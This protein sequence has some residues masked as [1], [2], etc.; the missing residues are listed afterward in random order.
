MTLKADSSQTGRAR[1]APVGLR[2][3]GGAPVVAVQDVRLPPRLQQELQRSLRSRPLHNR[4]EPSVD[5]RDVGDCKRL[6]SAYICIGA[7]HG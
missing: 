3:A 4:F 2:Q 7:R 6:T 1:R 5:A